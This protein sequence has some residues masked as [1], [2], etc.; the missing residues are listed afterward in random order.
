MTRTE[1]VWVEPQALIVLQ[2]RSI[3]LHGGVDGLRDPGLLESA[4]QR[5][6]NRYLY[7]DEGDLARLAGAYAIA[8]SANHPF[9]DGNK[10]AAFQAM[11]L[12][13]RLNGLRLAADQ[14]EAARVIFTLAAGDLDEGVLSEWIRGRMIPA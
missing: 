12:F 4:L 1:P 9:N 3:F 5:P 8:V 7:E 13:L 14:A 2:A 10:R 6:K 11:A